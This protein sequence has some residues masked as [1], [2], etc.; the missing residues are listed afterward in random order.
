MD[1]SMKASSNLMLSQINVQSCNSNPNSIDAISTGI[2]IHAW[3]V[4]ADVVQDSQW[5]DKR[6]LLIRLPTVPID[7]VYQS[8]HGLHC[9]S[10]DD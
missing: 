4:L 9:G 10:A 7:I 5:R 6:V 2:A 1:N 3:I 8:C